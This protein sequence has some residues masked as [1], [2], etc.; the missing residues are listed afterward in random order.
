MEEC[1]DE[2]DTHHCWLSAHWL[3]GLETQ[4]SIRRRRSSGRGTLRR[5]PSSREDDEKTHALVLTRR[6][7]LFPSRHALLFSARCSPLAQRHAPHIH[8]CMSHEYTC[9]ATEAPK[10]HIPDPAVALAS[11][12]LPLFLDYLRVEE[13]RTATTLLR[14]ESHL[15]KSITTVGDCP[16]GMPHYKGTESY[17]PKPSIC[18]CPREALLLPTA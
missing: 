14:Y 6:G 18:V 15:Q 10:Q 12:M 17:H 16:R 1:D 2:R 4:Q 5:T 11:E 9:P 7:I 8:T 13:H 3:H